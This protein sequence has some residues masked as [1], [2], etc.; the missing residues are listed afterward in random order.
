MTPILKHWFLN[1]PR[2]LDALTPQDWLSPNLN[3]GP[4]NPDHERYQEGLAQ[5]RE[6]IAGNGSVSLSIGSVWAAKG[7]DAK[8]NAWHVTSCEKVGY[9]AGSLAFWAG[10]LASGCPLILYRLEE[11]RVVAHHVRPRPESRAA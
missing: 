9:H 10:V 2:T 7:T 6:A 3:P 8:G 11:G 5:G 4:V 1:N